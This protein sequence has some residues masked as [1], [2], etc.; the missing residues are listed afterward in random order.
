MQSKKEWMLLSFMS[1]LILSSVLVMG[2][3][4][5][6]PKTD[7]PLT[8]QIDEQQLQETTND[9]QNGESEMKEM[10]DDTK[11][12]EQ[13]VKKEEQPSE[14]K[15]DEQPALETSSPSSEETLD[16]N[17]VQSE[18]EDTDQLESE[19]RVSES[20]PSEN[21]SNDQNGSITLTIPNEPIK[22]ILPAINHDENE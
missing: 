20:F 9:Q 14:D 4:I 16:E 6:K 3:I 17:P 13:P 12:Q 19:P 21:K 15:L 7:T 1:F 8:E 22:P 11:D 5:F 18:E 10:T 2:I